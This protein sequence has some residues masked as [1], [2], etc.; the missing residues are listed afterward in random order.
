MMF[1][2]LIFLNVFE[3]CSCYNVGI[4]YSIVSPVQGLF[5]LPVP[6][7]K[8]RYLKFHYIHTEALL[9][10]ICFLLYNIIPDVYISVY[11]LVF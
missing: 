7:L 11:S 8:W 4:V 10:S 6:Y 2:I 5:A 1:D 3:Y 9:L